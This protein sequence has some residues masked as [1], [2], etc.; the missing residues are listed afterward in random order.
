[1]LR[2]STE[3]P[4][5][6]L[7]GACSEP[8][9]RARLGARLGACSEHA[10]HL[11][12]PEEQLPVLL[13]DVLLEELLERVDALARHAAV[14]GVGEVELAAVRDARDRVDLDRDGHA[15][16]G[17]VDGLPIVLEPDDAPDVEVGLLRVRV[18]VRARIR[19]RVRARV[20]V[21]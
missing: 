13:G 9:L 14:E 7:L 11:L 16:L 5:S 21:R 17:A 20:R 19:A 2:A 4:P 8:V 10:E 18:R 15:R 12:E 1:M 3:P 6:A